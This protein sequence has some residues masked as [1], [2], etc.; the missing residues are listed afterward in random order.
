MSD[1]YTKVLLHFNAGY[2]ADYIDDF[3]STK[4]WTPVN[5]HTDVSNKVFGRSGINFLNDDSYISTPH[6]TDFVLGMDD[7][8]FDFWIL[9]RAG[10]SLPLF[11]CSNGITDGYRLYLGDLEYGTTNCSIVFSVTLSSSVVLYRKFASSFQYFG[12]NSFTHIEFSREG[13]DFYLFENG[14]RKEE[15]GSPVGAGDLD[16]PNMSSTFYI[17]RDAT[18]FGST[19]FFG[20]MDEF[21]FSK[22]IARHTENF[23]PPTSAYKRSGVDDEYTAALL[24]FNGTH[25]SSTVVD[26]VGAD[27]TATNAT[28]T[29]AEKYLGT[30]AID[31]DNDGNNPR[32]APTT[33]PPRLALMHRDN[34][35]VDYWV[36]PVNFWK[37]T[38]LWS[39]GNFTVM[40]ENNGG[41]QIVMSHAGTVLYNLASALT[42]GVWQHH[43]FIKDMDDLLFYV[44]GT[45]VGTKDISTLILDQDTVEERATSIFLAG[46]VNTWSN[47]GGSGFY[48]EVRVS[49]DI[50]RWSG[51]FTPQ[52]YEYGATQI[53]ATI[54]FAATSTLGLDTNFR[55]LDVAIDS[56]DI[57]TGGFYLETSVAFAGDVTYALV[58]AYSKSVAFAVD[59]TY[60]L[61]PIA[62]SMGDAEG[63]AATAAFTCYKHY[64]GNTSTTGP[65]ATITGKTGYSA[66][67]AFDFPLAE[68]DAT[69]GLDC[70]F[71]IP[72]F[73][74]SSAASIANVGAA[75]VKFPKFTANSF[76]FLGING[77]VDVDVPVFSCS[78]TATFASSLTS[79]IYF[80]TFSIGAT[81]SQGVDFASYILWHDSEG[82]V[83]KSSTTFPVFTC[84][85]AAS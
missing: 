17:G 82:F 6:H 62:L 49:L 8:T 45:L 2:L 35:T 19:C 37:V 63:I 38:S 67:A 70:S 68:V 26:S 18:L 15:I 27:W 34:F 50:K 80:P 22:G 65:V 28:L 46:L 4:E 14:T 81:A 57:F 30:A 53:E 32:T 20:S 13:S 83:A 60:G 5:I 39:V 52:D 12:E 48:D 54:D 41:A 84:T 21:R 69:I 61:G 74:L 16:I 33:F 79:G 3:G 78:G 77:D 51:N 10:T 73:T 72:L 64:I 47:T 56:S 36:K 44:N 11:S 24:H 66:T 31:C 71:D 40:V 23:T 29:T 1:T 43:A 76:V 58:P 42:E 85:G 55:D 75:T 9:K 25:G 59:A 7:F